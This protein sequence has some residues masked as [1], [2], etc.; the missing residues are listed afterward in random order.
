MGSCYNAYLFTLLIP[1]AVLSFI[2][3]DLGPDPRF[4][5]ITGAWNLGGAIFVTVGGRLSDIFGRRYFFLTGSTILIVG[6]IVS[7]TGQSISQMIAGGALFGA[8]SGFLEMAFGAVQ[9]IVPN[10][11]RMTTIGLFD[12]SS[13]IAQMMPL[14]AWGII[15]TTGS[16]RAS[17][18]M[19]IG[20]QFLNLVF[21]FF[22]YHPPAF[23]TKHRD[24]GKTKRQLLLEFDWVGLFLFITGCTLFIIG[25]GWGGTLHPWRSAATIAPI[26]IG[27]SM[28]IGLGFWEVYGGVKEPLLPPRLFK[29]V[30]HFLMP[31]IAMGITG[32]QYYSN[33]TLVRASIL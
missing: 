16:W 31:C 24:D 32:M 20:F 11:W 25:L 5:W 28:L 1:P 17:Y 21:L 6:S 22:F 12:A 2:N 23:H 7:A 8:G 29:Q 30:R 13:I 15:Q 18:Y 33:A 26:I 4:T 10:E 27:F 3:A 14:A 19:M 9:E